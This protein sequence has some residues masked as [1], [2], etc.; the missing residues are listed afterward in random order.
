M[1][2]LFI[3]GKE[4]VGTQGQKHTRTSVN[5]TDEESIAILVRRT[6]QPL[7]RITVID[8]EFYC[9]GVLQCERV[10]GIDG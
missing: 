4:S 5:D 2:S 1:S 6:R 9:D 3:F 10:I 7:V 8:I